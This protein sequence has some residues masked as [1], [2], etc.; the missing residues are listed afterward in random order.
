MYIYRL[1]AADGDGDVLRYYLLDTPFAMT[2]DGETGEI[3]WLPLARGGFRIC[4][5]VTDGMF[6]ATQSF[7]IDVWKNTPPVI[8]SEPPATVFAGQKY[9]YDL[10]VFDEEGDRLDHRLVSAP[11]GMSVDNRTGRIEWRPGQNQLGDHAVSVLV[12]DGMGCETR[13]DFNVRVMDARPHCRI[14]PPAGGWIFNG[15]MQVQGKATRGMA[16]L[17]RIELRVDDGEW[18][19]ALGRE[20]WS[21]DL[22]TLRLPDG[23]H[24]LRARA[25]D[26]NYSEEASV[27]FAI[28]TPAPGQSGSATRGIPGMSVIM[29]ALSVAFLLVLHRRPLR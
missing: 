11:P 12:A 25:F 5:K 7:T 17:S 2:V 26:G 6:W 10:L 28:I 13:Q 8:L 3:C 16:P 19:A 1:A 20:K 15:A 9:C 14:N 27:Q 21:Y 24:T 29:F 4:V 18:F 23:P 22:G